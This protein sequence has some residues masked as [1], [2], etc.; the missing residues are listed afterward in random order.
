MTPQKLGAHV[1]NSAHQINVKDARFHS[2]SE[3]RINLEALK[4]MTVPPLYLGSKMTNYHVKE[5]GSAFVVGTD[6][7]EILV[8]ADRKLATQIVIEAQNIQPVEITA[9]H[10]LCEYLQARAL[11]RNC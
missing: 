5:F 9:F 1:V 8:C 11:L 10:A 7:E 6:D 3:Q 4:G 2:I